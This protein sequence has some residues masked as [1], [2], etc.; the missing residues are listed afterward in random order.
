MKKYIP[1]V[2]VVVVGILIVSA[3]FAGRAPKA[4]PSPET[5]VVTNTFEQ[6][7]AQDP[8]ISVMPFATENITKQQHDD[9]RYLNYSTANFD[10]SRDK[11]RVLFFYASWCPTCRP[12]DTDFT[13]NMSQI[14]EDVVVFR[15]NYNDPDTDQDE[16]DLAEQYGITYQH[17]FVQIDALGQAVKKWNGGKLNELLTN[18]Q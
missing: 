12:A 3:Y 15:V 18:I 6:P 14:P 16:K 4:E 17:T 8:T 10:Q 11:I 2:I 1:I 7:T 5:S 13:N 9:L